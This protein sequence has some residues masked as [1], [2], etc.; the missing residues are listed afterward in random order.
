MRYYTPAVL[1]RQ[2]ATSAANSSRSHRFWSTALKQHLPA[3]VG[4]YAILAVPSLATCYMICS[5]R[6]HDASAWILGK[7]G[8]DLTKLDD[9]VIGDVSLLIFAH[10]IHTATVPYRIGASIL[11]SPLIVRVL[12]ARRIIRT[13]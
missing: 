6:D 8:F 9:Q 4:V 2:A 10:A 5:R 11:L 7:L 12:R 13:R 1:R 3:A